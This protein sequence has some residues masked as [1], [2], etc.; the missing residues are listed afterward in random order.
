MEKLKLISLRIEPETLAKIDELA[1]RHGY[2]TRS[3]IINRLLAN[4]LNCSDKDT[5]WRM[6]STYNAHQIGY[7]VSFKVN[8]EKLANL[9]KE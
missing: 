8:A 2:Y 9:P 1:K 7:E 6:L 5:L 3:A 4:V